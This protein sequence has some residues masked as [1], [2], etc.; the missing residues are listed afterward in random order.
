MFL[1]WYLTARQPAPDDCAISGSVTRSFDAS[2]AVDFLTT[3]TIAIVDDNI[4]EEAETIA[5]PPGVYFLSIFF[6]GTTHLHRL[7]KA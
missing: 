3:T 6:D 2:S 1:C 5:I 4:F 7:L